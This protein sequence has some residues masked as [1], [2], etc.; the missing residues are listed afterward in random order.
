MNLVIAGV[1]G[2][3]LAHCESSIKLYAYVFM[4]HHYHMIIQVEDHQSLSKFI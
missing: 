4:S 1:L 3:A 2:R